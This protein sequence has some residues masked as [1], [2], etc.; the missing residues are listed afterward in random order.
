MFLPHSQ[1]RLGCCGP[2]SHSEPL[3]QLTPE[4]CG[5]LLQP[6]FEYRFRDREKTAGVWVLVYLETNT[7]LIL[8]L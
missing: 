2:A 5:L 3:V 1:V 8:T 7:V 6:S 4:V